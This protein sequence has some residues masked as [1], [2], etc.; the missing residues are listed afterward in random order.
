MKNH[1]T[2]HNE[3]WLRHYEKNTFYIHR[4]YKTKADTFRNG[5]AQVNNKLMKKN[6]L[7][8]KVAK[9]T[10]PRF[11]ERLGKTETI[12]TKLLMYWGKDKKKPHVSQRM[13][14]HNL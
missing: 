10:E 5:T 1:D 13:A 7:S 6:F 3:P 9:K 12:K 4:K 11:T 8:T 14:S 2:F